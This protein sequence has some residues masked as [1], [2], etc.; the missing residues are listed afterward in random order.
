MKKKSWN[1]KHYNAI[2]KEIRRLF[3]VDKTLTESGYDILQYADY[4]R[5][6]NQSRSILTVLAYNLA[7][8]FMVDSNDAENDYAFDPRKFLNACSPDIEIYPLGDLWED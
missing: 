3:P 2:S 1:A 6:N 4:R 8:R 5:D 7:T